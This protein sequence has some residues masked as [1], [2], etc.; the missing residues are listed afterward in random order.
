MGLEFYC[1][2]VSQPCRAVYIF[3]K[4]TGVP[5][6]L[7]TLELRKGTFHVYIM[8]IYSLI[9]PLPFVRLKRAVVDCSCI[10]KI[11]KANNVDR[12]QLSGSG[13]TMPP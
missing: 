8:Y 12:A 5:F 10:L 4:V 6:E 1:D 2:L 7:K 13:I 3:L 9:V 11:S